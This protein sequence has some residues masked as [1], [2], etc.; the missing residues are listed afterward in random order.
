MQHE[1]K[2]NGDNVDISAE[3]AGFGDQ[4]PASGDPAPK[5]QVQLDGKSISI[6]M[7]LGPKE[8]KKPKH[9]QV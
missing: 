8:S 2:Q 1:V 3:G 7:I 4:Q 6:G 5:Q 9:E